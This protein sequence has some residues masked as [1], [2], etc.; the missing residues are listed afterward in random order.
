MSKTP[1]FTEFF[2]AFN[3]LEVSEEYTQAD[4]ATQRELERNAF[5]QWDGLL[6]PIV[7]ENLETILEVI[8]GVVSVPGL[9]ALHV[10]H[11]FGDWWYQHA[12]PYATYPW[13]MH[14]PVLEEV[15]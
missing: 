1:T 8:H 14:A 13:K 2:E 10:A 6:V 11:W 9:D 15:S 3:A 4:D 5:C 12:T 7:V